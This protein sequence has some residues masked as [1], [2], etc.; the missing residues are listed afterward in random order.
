MFKFKPTRKTYSDPIAATFK[1]GIPLGRKYSAGDMCLLHDGFQGSKVFLNSR[2]LRAALLNSKEYVEEVLEIR[3]TDIRD[4]EPEEVKDMEVVE[5]DLAKGDVPK[6]GDELILDSE[7]LIVGNTDIETSDLEFPELP[8][9]DKGEITEEVIIEGVNEIPEGA[10]VVDEVVIDAPA[11]VADAIVEN[12]TEEVKEDE[13]P[14][15]KK[16]KKT[17]KK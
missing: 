1:P 8:E 14:V 4:N 15:E 2:V 7:D 16:T 6:S 12:I 17:S 13:A 11:E 3:I 5:A 9:E 10:E